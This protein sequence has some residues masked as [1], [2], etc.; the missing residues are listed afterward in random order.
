MNAVTALSWVRSGELN[1]SGV[2]NLSWNLSGRGVRVWDLDSELSLARL[3][4][5]VAIVVNVE[6]NVD[7]GVF[8]GPSTELEITVSVG[9]SRVQKIIGV[10]SILIPELH[11]NSSSWTL[12]ANQF[13]ANSRRLVTTEHFD[14]GGHTEQG[15]NDDE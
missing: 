3:D 5:V 6:L 2:I 13:S 12:I 11:E 4:S 1:D 9:G 15:D 10:Q 7:W 14:R 8:L